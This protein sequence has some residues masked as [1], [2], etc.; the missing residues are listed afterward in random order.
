MAAFD[1]FSKAHTLAWVREV[2]YRLS[3]GE[4]LMSVESLA[5]QKRHPADYRDDLEYRHPN[6]RREYFRP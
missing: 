4:I 6:P 3:E 1:P 2:E 5:R